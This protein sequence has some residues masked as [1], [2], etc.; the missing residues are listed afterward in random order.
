[1]V[2]SRATSDCHSFADPITIATPPLVTAARNVM[3]ATTAASA[4]AAIE[5]FGTMWTW[6]RVS[7]PGRCGRRSKRANPLRS[8][9]VTGL[10]IDVDVAVMEHKATGVVLVHE[11]DVV[12]GDDDRGAG[13]VQLDEQPEQALRQLRI[14]I[15]GRLIG[16]QEL[17]P[18]DHGAGDGG[19]LLLAAREHRRPRP[20]MFPEPD[21]AQQLG[22]LVVV[23]LLVAADDAQR[24]RNIVES[25][26]MVEEPEVLEHHPDPPPQHG[27]RIG[28]QGGG[29]VIEQRDQSPGRLERQKQK[30][31]QRTLAGAG[32]TAEK[33]E[34]ARRN[35]EGEVAQ[36][37]GAEPVA[38]SDILELNHAV[39]RIAHPGKTI[40]SRP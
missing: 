35:V 32:G 1:M 29:V 28:A 33:L 16:E 20:H 2:I 13:F 22:D 25:S 12:G 21:P 3:I 30:A 9:A 4:L 37:F 36:N 10:V 24:Q 31:Q 26:E 27:E 19:A 14:H 18:G 6:P 34:R 40:A 5:S 17:R 7:R 39:L 38:Q 23:T 11:G 8:A 15:A